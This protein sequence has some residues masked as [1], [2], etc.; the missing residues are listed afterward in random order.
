M[1][2]NQFEII[3]NQFVPYEMALKLK[4]LGFNERCVAHWWWPKQPS[5]YIDQRFANSQSQMKDGVKILCLAPLWQQIIDWFRE[6]HQL[7]VLLCPERDNGFGF[8]ILNIKTKTNIT[9]EELGNF[10]IEP[11]FD[12][13]EEAREQAIL[14]ALTLIK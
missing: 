4:Q 3:E 12:I 6:K 9:H 1:K 11:R 13:Y 7:F 10:E 8:K 14:K 2:E 5:L